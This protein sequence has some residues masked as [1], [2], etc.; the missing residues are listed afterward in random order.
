MHQ[1]RDPQSQILAALNAYFATPPAT[2]DEMV[3]VPLAPDVWRD[4]ILAARGTRPRPARRH[5]RRPASGPALLRPARPRSG[6]ARIRRWIARTGEALYEHDASP[7]AGYAHVLRVRNGALDLPGGADA[8][9]IWDALVGAPTAD[10]AAA[11]LG[12]ADPRQRTAR[13]LRRSRSRRSIPRTSRSCFLPAPPPTRV[14]PVARLAYRSFVTVD[15]LRISPICRSSASPT[16]L[17]RSWRRCRS[18]PRARWTAPRST[19]RRCSRA[20]TCRKIPADA[21]PKLD[22]S[23]PATVAPLL[24]RLAAEALPGRQD[25]LATVDLLARLQ[26]RMPGTTPADR[27]WLAHAFRRYPSLL[28]TLER[29]GV[30]DLPVWKA[31]AHQ[32]RHLDAPGRRRR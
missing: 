5:P 2:G 21:W 10:A 8:A 6:D 19:G 32:A 27:V 28:L 17:E 14:S 18:M 1:A 22:E 3:P 12:A 4:Q 23:E 11:I 26:R 31:L 20:T 15:A 9:P 13:L 16:I 7:F 29:I 30:A 24:D 25:L